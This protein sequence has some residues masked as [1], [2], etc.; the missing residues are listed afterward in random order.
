[1]EPTSPE[2]EVLDIVTLSSKGQLA[3][4]VEVRERMGL[5]KGARLMVIL[6]KDGKSVILRTVSI[7]EVAKSHMWYLSNARRRPGPAKKQEPILDSRPQVES[8]G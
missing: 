5:S 6:A 3:L 4:P 1:M 2:G 8:N 7:E